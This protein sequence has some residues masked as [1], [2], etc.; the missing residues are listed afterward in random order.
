ML[1]RARWASW[2]FWLFFIGFN[3]TFFPMHML[4]LMGMP[5]RVYTYP[6]GLGWDLP[7]LIAVDRLLRDRG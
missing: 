7:N 1:G 4:G 3:V 2:Q 5:R 6:P